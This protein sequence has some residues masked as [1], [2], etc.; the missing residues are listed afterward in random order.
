MA[1]QVTGQVPV[2]LLGDLD[3]SCHHLRSSSLWMARKAAEDGLCLRLCM[4]GSFNTHMSN[5]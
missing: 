4:L 3:S 1:V 2:E 5:Y